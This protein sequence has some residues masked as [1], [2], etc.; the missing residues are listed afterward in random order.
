MKRD[1]PDAALLMTVCVLDRK[2][3]AACGEDG[4]RSG[5]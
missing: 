3:L 1:S 4:Q 2:T 5:G